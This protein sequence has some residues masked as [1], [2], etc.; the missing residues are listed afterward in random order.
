MWTNVYIKLLKTHA[1]IKYFFEYI[2]PVFPSSPFDQTQF[3]QVM[4][5]TDHLII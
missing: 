4:G 1:P 5:L 2:S 3:L